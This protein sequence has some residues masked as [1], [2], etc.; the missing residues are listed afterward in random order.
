VSQFGIK[1]FPHHCEVPFGAVAVQGDGTAP[2]GP[3]LPRFARDDCQGGQA[4]KLR[5]RLKKVSICSTRVDSGLPAQGLL[6]GLVGA[7]APAC[8]GADDGAHA[9]EQVGAPSGAEPAGDLAVGGRGPQLSFGAVVVGRHLGMVEEGEQV[10]AELA[11]SLPQP[12]AVTMGGRQCHDGIECAL[13]TPSVFA[14]GAC[15]QVTAPSGEHDSAQQQC[16]HAR[17]EHGVA[18][19]GG[20]GAVTELMGQADLPRLGMAL[21]RAVEV[22]HPE[23]R[24]VPVQ[25]LG[26]HAGAPA[27]ANDMDD[28]LA[29]LEDPVPYV[30]GPLLARCFAVL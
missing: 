20:V 30:D 21:L 18:G 12:L 14:P 8:G 27:T 17:S 29:V 15:G 24:P 22:R 5:H 6:N 7:Y 10:R 26:H 28:H 19:L 1:A 25:H 23:R 3:G 16:L 2:R 4:F 13:E 11:V 9:C